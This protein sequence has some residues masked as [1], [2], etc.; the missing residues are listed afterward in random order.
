[1]NFELSRRSHKFGFLLRSGFTS[2]MKNK[3]TSYT[4]K[5]LAN[6]CRVIKKNM[7]YE[8]KTL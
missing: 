7:I 2:Y 1:M 8:E 3:E 5:T 4:K 6:S